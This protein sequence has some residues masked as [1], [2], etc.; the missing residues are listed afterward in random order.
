MAQA[1]QTTDTLAGW[2]PG[3]WYPGHL[4]RDDHACNC[5][6][7]LSE[8]YAGAICEVSVNND[9]P[10]SEGGND[11]PPLAEAKANQ[12]LIAAAP[13]LYAA[14]SELREAVSMEGVPPLFGLANPVAQHARI[15]AA[16]ER[17]DAALR[18]A[19]EGR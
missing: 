17:A 12:R 16:L 4:C 19:K 15:E 5:P 1:T 14:L 9:L 2:T 6:Y 18:L 3:P 7:V 11:A 8:G 13:D 10:I